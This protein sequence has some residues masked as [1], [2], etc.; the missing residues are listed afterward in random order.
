MHNKNLS[1]MITLLSV[2]T[3]SPT[4]LAYGGGGAAAV[5]AVARK[6]GFTRNNPPTIPP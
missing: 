6:P 3:F 2:L 1:T 4:L 5:A